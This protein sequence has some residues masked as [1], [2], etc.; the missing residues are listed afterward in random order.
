MCGAEVKGPRESHLESRGQSWLSEFGPGDLGAGPAAW[1]RVVCSVR[2][3]AL[4]LSKV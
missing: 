2:L 3:S 4:T 1:G